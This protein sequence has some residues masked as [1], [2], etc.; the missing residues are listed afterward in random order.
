VWSGLIDAAR[1]GQRTAF[2]RKA[3]AIGFLSRNL[4]SLWS[5]ARR[6]GRKTTGRR[7]K[8]GKAGA[9]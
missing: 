3:L 8:A 6:K 7:A 2:D 1:A 4:D 9:A 5:L